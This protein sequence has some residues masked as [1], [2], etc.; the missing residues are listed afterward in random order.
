MPQNKTIQALLEGKADNH[1]LPFSGSTVR[2]KP[3]CA[4]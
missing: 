3:P 4:R 1:I 2:M